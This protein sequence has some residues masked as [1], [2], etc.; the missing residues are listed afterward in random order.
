MKTPALL[1]APRD[2]FS[3]LIEHP[4]YTRSR[5]PRH[6]P[7]TLWL[8]LARG[9]DGCCPRSRRCSINSAT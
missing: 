8:S 4:N 7:M 9:P 2:L 6:A 3:E 5:A 1:R